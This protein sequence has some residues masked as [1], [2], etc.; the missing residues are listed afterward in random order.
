MLLSVS[1]KDM[2]YFL[3]YGA[4]L[5]VQVLFVLVILRPV[6]FV[7]VLFVRTPGDAGVQHHGVTLFWP[8]TMQ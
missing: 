5:F 7:Q 1:N 8:L 2:K 4:V 3:S 6:L